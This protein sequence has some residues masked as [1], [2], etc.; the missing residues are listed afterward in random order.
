[1]RSLPPLLATALLALAPAAASAAD[2]YV[3]D[4]GTGADCTQAE[5]CPTIAEG[6]AAAGAGETVHVADGTYPTQVTLGEGKSLVADGD[7][8]VIDAGENPGGTG[9]SPFDATAAVTVP[10]GVAGATTTIEGLRFVTDDD[11]EDVG[12]Y[13]VDVVG[14]G[15]TIRENSFDGFSWGAIRMSGDDADVLVAGNE[16]TGSPEAGNNHP[17]GVE[18]FAGADPTLRDNLI[19]RPGSGASTAISLQDDPGGAVTGATLLRN[20]IH[21]FTV[22][23]DVTNT[24]GDVSLDG[25]LITGGPGGGWGVVAE[26]ST[27]GAPD[28]GEGDVSLTNVTLAD[29]TSSGA[30]DDTF[31]DLATIG[32][33]LSL[34]SVL[35]EDSIK[36]FTHTGEVGTCSIAFSRGPTTTGDACASFQTSAPPE[37]VD[38]AAGDYHLSP[39]SALIDAGDPTAPTNPTDFDGDPRALAGPDNGRTCGDGPAVRDIGADELDCHERGIT[40]SYSKRKDAFRGRL[41]SDE[42]GCTQAEVTL[43]RKRRG[44]AAALV[45]TDGT[46]AAGR[47]SIPDD[48]PRPGRYYAKVAQAFDSAIGLCPA[49]RSPILRL[50]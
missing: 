19:H 37:F 47:Y 14:S 4:D 45:G 43:R 10:S 34:N 49:K 21:D 30:P 18:I 22:G 46:N 1:M 23:V 38:P 40:L 42:L 26:D 2:S 25:D 50:R 48:S 7:G 39:T 13:G 15:P 29:N 35:V 31:G 32:A 5:P 27:A 16:I 41:T 44:R 20:R 24:E 6:I 36:L 8:A 12:R 9:L 17:T 3:D 28:G 33:T 11:D